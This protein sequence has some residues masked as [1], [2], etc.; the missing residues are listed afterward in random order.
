MFK[1]EREKGGIPG[2][3]LLGSCSLPGDFSLLKQNIMWC[4]KIG[5]GLV[6]KDFKTKP[7]ALAWCKFYCPKGRVYPQ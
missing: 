6:A 1:I 5:K 2:L 7:E 3:G 4:V